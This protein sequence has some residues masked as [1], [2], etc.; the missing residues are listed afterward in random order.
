MNTL[1]NFVLK[2]TIS[3]GKKVAEELDSATKN[4]CEEQTK[5]LKSIILKSANTRYGNKYHFLEIDSFVDYEKNV[6]MTNYDNLQSYIE[7]MVKGEKNVLTKDEIVHFNITSG[8][9]GAPKK[10]PVT[11]DHVSLFSKF[12]AGYLN[13]VVSKKIGK[14][15]TKGK[16]LSLS[17]GTYKIL[18][19]GVSI[20]SASSL[21]TARMAKAMPFIKIDSMDLMYTS[22]KEARQPSE[23]G[24]Y[25]RYLHALFAL[26]EENITYGNVTFSSLL[27]EF[28]RYIELNWKVLCND[29]EKGTVDGASDIPENEKNSV[30]KKIKP[31]PLRAKKLREIFLNHIN[32][33]FAKLIWPK[34]NFFMCVAG[35][36]F[37]S[38]TNKLIERYFGD[39]IHFLY[40]GLSSS[41][42]LYSVPLRMDSPDSVLIPNGIYM[43]FIPIVLG[44]RDLSL[45]IKH[46]WELEKGKQYE[47]VITNLSGLYRY[48]LKDVIE[49]TGF[50]NNTP[51]I[52]FVNRSGFAIN[53]CAEKTSHKALQYTAQETCK[54]LNLDL[55]DY[56]VCPKSDDNG[57]RYIFMYEIHSDITNINMQKLR[58][59]TE[60]Y[61]IEAN[62][63]YLDERKTGNLQQTE[64]R[65]LQNE[66]FMLYRDLMAMKGASLA[67]LKPIHVT[68]TPF[69]EGF[70]LKLVEQ[71]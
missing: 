31:N 40:L 64:V 68:T 24:T 23:L 58:D 13:Y 34:L 57:S 38:Y 65:I 61:L 21:H 33:P 46:L 25:S 3:K 48:E 11:E 26:K 49:V 18:D 66:T 12:N 43:E 14:D 45:G 19:T 7:C 53:M 56:C 62:P 36:G 35:D 70:F 60:K 29:I 16:G 69:Q 15:W 50:Y 39:D 20:G 27:L 17:E 22:P 10:I 30:L 9:M 41:E 44:N 67:Q 6:P 8:T 42:G 28:M 1:V 55:Y 63:D 37:Q 4:P 5:L 59:V 32:E 2:M 52:Q 47:L 54:E 71:I 51:T